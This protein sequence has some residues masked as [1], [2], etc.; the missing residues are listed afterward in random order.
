MTFTPGYRGFLGFCA[1][2]GVDLA[3]FQ[4]LIARA[5]F[6]TERELAVILP[7]GSAKT[8][9]AALLA[10][11]HLVT[12]PD[13]SVSLG[14]ASRE[15]A[16]IAF[17]VMREAA[18]HPALAHLVTVRHLALRADAG[19]LLRVVSGRGERAH[20]QTD[21]LMLADEVWCWPD[22]KLLEAFQTALVKRPDAR[23]VMIS[24]AASTLDSPLGRQR[25]RA[26]AGEVSQ[27]AAFIDSRAA[28][29]RWLEWSVREGADLDDVREVKKAN[30][31]PWITLEALREQ[32]ARV[33]P[34]AW[35]QFHACRWGVG[36][37]AWLP[38]GA[39]S[40]CRSAY[41]VEEGETVTLGVDVGGSRAASAVVAVTDD[42][43]VAAVE[44]FEGNDSVLDVTEA[45]RRLAQGFV[46]REVA[47]DPWRFKSEALR[48]EGEGI[49]PMVEFPQSHA[50]MVPASERL[51]ATIVEERL[52]HYGDPDL[53]RHVAHA[54]AKPT[55]R[56]WR[57]DKS[58]RGAQ[59]DAA[60][61][62]AMAVERA[63]FRPEPVRV[64]AWL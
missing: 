56:G 29:L 51:H 17:Q 35:A 6:G 31:A 57:L 32:H 22:D 50:R 10:L 53:D 18:E 30:P 2:I 48:L 5:A 46:V 26:L 27:R 58:E 19:G 44:V 23:L 54:V 16:S 24:T 20:G 21:S 12:E 3:P 28:G 59:I 47:Y 15:Q 60:V 42:L 63:E 36:E 61:A 37:G 1:A 41:E 64:L 62:L 39:W 45:V 40:A 4:R 8:T 13:A 34:Q 43:R 11:H 55:G 52:R 9:T 33:T 14:A 7:R 38:P 25:V 49:G